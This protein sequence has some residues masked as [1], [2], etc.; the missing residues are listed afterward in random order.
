MRALAL[1]SLIAVLWVGCGVTRSV[2][3]ITSIPLT[4]VSVAAPKPGSL[5]AKLAELAA[6][7]GDVKRLEEEA[8]ELRLAPLRMCLMW[9]AGIG[10]LGVAICAG[11]AAA[12]LFW[13]LGFTW[14]IPAGIGLACLVA[15]LVALTAGWALNYLGWIVGA[16]ALLCVGGVA[17]L[18]KHQV[19]LADAARKAWDHVPEDA[20]VHPKLEA[21]LDK[22]SK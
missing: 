6:A 21:F 12:A 20:I 1:L 5:D 3:K 10:L 15:V 14:K 19:N 13:G 7:K 22:L 11:L 16:M 17:W 8:A 4:P 2:P 18:V 9:V